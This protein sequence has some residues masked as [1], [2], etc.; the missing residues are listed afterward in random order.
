VVTS[1]APRCTRC[2]A[3]LQWGEV[4]CPYCGSSLILHPTAGPGSLLLGPF[5]R[6]LHIA[7]QGIVRSHHQLYDGNT[8]LGTFTQRWPAGVRFSSTRGYR[9]RTRRK[10][11]VRMVLHWTCGTT[12]VAWV[13]QSR[14]WIRRYRLHYGGA[15]YWLVSASPM[16]LVFDL[17]NEAETELAQIRPSPLLRAPHLIVYAPVALEIIALAY[18]TSLVLWRQA[19]TA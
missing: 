4:R 8:L 5:P 14:M 9:Y 15:R 13:E 17:R 16:S 18:A 3:D 11:M 6:E 19:V 1:G 10:R 12:L 2:G 7:R